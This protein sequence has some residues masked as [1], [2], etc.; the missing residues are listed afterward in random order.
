MNTPEKKGTVQFILTAK[1]GKT[2]Y[3][4]TPKE[5]YIKKLQMMKPRKVNSYRVA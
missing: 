1:D 2:K 4:L 3:I 5:E